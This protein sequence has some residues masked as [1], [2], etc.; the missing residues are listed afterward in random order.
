MAVAYASSAGK[1]VCRG[2]CED[3]GCCEA[4]GEEEAERVGLGV[5]E[6]GG[7]G[8]GD[9]FPDGV[10][11]RVAVGNKGGMAAIGNSGTVGVGVAVGDAVGVAV[12]SPT[13]N[14]YGEV[15]I[16]KKKWVGV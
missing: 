12:V 2:S 10:G 8:V 14:L 6:V 13:K 1:A 3:A 11:V 9:W 5:S 7:V 4:E 16:L 15:V